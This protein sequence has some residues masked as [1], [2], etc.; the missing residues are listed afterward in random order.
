MKKIILF[1]FFISVILFLFAEIHIGC[2]RVTISNSDIIKVVSDGCISDSS[3]VC[4]VSQKSI[5]IRGTKT[6]YYNK[7]LECY[8]FSIFGWRVFI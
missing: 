2:K 4:V 6:L 5:S 3:Y 8:G 7:P 1:T